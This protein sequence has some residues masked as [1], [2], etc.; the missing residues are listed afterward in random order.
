MTTDYHRII[1]IGAGKRGGGPASGACGSP[2]RHSWLARGGHVART[3]H[4]R[5]SW[6]DRGGYSRRS[7]L[8]RR[9]RA[10]GHERG[11]M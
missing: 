6:I 9:S 3:N 5:L 10:A 8:R 11:E 7:R 2:R 1:T 4:Q